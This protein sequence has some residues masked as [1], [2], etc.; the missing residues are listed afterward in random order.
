MTNKEM[1]ELA[2]KAAGL[3]VQDLDDNGGFVNGVH[4]NPLADDEAAMQLVVKLKLNV[5]WFDMN[6]NGVDDSYVVVKGS[7]ITNKFGRDFSGKTHEYR[8]AIVL[9]AASMGM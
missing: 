7:K 5:E 9:A 8:H 2:A 4:W 3:N 1:L 6:I